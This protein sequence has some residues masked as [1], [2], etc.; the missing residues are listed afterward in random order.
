MRLCHRLL[1]VGLLLVVL[2]SNQTVEASI[3]ERKKERPNGSVTELS[4]TF[5]E[6]HIPNVRHNRGILSLVCE[7]GSGEINMHLLMA[8]HRLRNS[9]KKNG[10][11]PTASVTFQ[12][13]S[14]ETAPQV[15]LRPHEMNDEYTVVVSTFVPKGLCFGPFIGLM[16]PTDQT[17]YQA[18]FT[19][20][21][22]VTISDMERDEKWSIKTIATGPKLRFSIGPTNYH[23]MEFY[24][25]CQKE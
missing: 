17:V 19:K 16:T 18:L 1:N 15:W 23:L 14:Q 6:D 22:Y 9:N 24:N 25:R 13:D 21:L 8:A 3:L 12:F 5:M 7:E 2:A 4:L 11:C 10:L 20:Y